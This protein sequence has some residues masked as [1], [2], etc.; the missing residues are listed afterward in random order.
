MLAL[1]LVVGGCRETNPEPSQPEI[2][3]EVLAERREAFM[4][5]HARL[6]E[7]Y[8]ALKQESARL[9][10]FRAPVVVRRP[11]VV[12]FYPV[13]MARL[14]SIRLRTFLT[15][16][17][18]RA[19][20]AGWAFEDRHTGSIGLWEPHAQAKYALPVPWDSL[21]FVLAAPAQLPQVLYDDSSVSLLPARLHSLRGWLP[22]AGGQIAEDL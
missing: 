1:I 22:G 13:W 6:T 18:L 9:A 21:G 5:D 2:A 4:R 15:A 10:P 17:R 20:Q 8:E 3:P 16:S 19:A 7:Q 12:A 11:T 14:D